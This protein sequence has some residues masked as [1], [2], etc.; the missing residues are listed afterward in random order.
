MGYLDVHPGYSCYEILPDRHGVRCSGYNPKRGPLPP[1]I[2]RVTDIGKP[3]VPTL[4]KDDLETISEIRAKGYK[5]LQFAFLPH[6]GLVVFDAPGVPCTML[7]GHYEILNMPS[8]GWVFS[9]Y[10]SG[11]NPYDTKA[12]GN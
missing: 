1:I 10:E 4:A 2:Y 12:T 3:G 8:D 5:S 6:W 11:E 9:F 7:P